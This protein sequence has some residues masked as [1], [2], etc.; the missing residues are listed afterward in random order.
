MARR[1]SAAVPPP[2]PPKCPRPA[3][4]VRPKR[5][6]WVAHIEK[7]F[8]IV[9]LWFHCISQSLPNLMKQEFSLRKWFD[10]QHEF[11]I[12]PYIEYPIDRG[13]DVS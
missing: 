11:A 3:P 1:G 9:S 5:I 8:A 13:R 7:K 6:N 2:S 4:T 10:Q 12:K